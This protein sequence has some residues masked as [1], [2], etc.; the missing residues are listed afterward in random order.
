MST[1]FKRGFPWLESL[2]GKCCI[3]HSSL[4]FTKKDVW[5]FASILVVDSTSHV[6]ELEFLSIFTVVVITRLHSVNLEGWVR[7]EKSCMCNGFVRGFTL[8]SSD[9]KLQWDCSYVDWQ[10][11]CYSVSA[12]QENPDLWKWISGQE[13]PPESVSA[14][15][16]CFILRWI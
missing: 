8:P 1:S 11:L 4:L 6:V 7:T 13:Q 16:V 10:S 3:F 15:L 12:L 14:N 9:G 5:W 2:N